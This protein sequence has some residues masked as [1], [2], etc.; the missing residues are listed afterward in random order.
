MPKSVVWQYSRDRTPL[1]GA[2]REALAA[3]AELLD[4]LPGYADPGPSTASTCYVWPTDDCAVGCA[5]CN[6]ASPRSSD[7]I[8]RHRIAEDVDRTMEFVNGM[9]L[10][11]AV[12][13][14]GGEPMQEP[15]FCQEFIARV[16]S[17]QLREVELITSG[18][19]A[20]S[21]EDARHGIE[22]LVAAWRG[23]PAA[24]A[25]AAFTL[26]ISVDWFHA[27]R[28]GLRPVADILEVLAARSTPASAATS[29][30]SCWTATPPSGTSPCSS[31]PTCRP[32]RTTSRR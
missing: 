26:R 29:V 28:I 14:G 21:R 20:T 22:G 19:F 5:H 16:D 24:R 32:S 25:A 31:G 2:A 1:P 30:P 8:P 6:F 3:R 10:W 7:S 9:G 13:S 27:A 11:K 15:A 12:L 18:S 23:R 17:P 4:S